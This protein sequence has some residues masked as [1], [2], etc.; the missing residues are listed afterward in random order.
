MIIWS[1]HINKCP[2]EIYY[3]TPCMLLEIFGMQPAPDM[4]WQ[5]HDYHIL[6]KWWSFKGL[7]TERYKTN[8]LYLVLHGCETLLF[9]SLP[10]HKFYN[11]LYV[12][13]YHITSTV[14]TRPLKQI[15]GSA[16]SCGLA[17]RGEFNVIHTVCN[18]LTDYTVFNQTNCT[19]IHK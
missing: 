6:C 18:K 1:E 7:M 8:V 15:K 13:I 11:F 4:E 17:G 16:V 10:T 14:D 3:T 2:V 12:I 9:R 19:H 5:W